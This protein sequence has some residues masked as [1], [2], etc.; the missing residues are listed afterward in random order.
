MKRGHSPETSKAKKIKTSVGLS[1]QENE[2]TGGW[3][4]VEKRKQKKARKAEVQMVGE[5]SRILV[6]TR[7][8]TS[9]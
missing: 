3:T 5:L 4:K 1:A 7:R 6:R 9:V 8:R 2:E